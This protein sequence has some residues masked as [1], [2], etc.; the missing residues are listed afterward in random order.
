MRQHQPMKLTRTAGIPKELRSSIQEF[1]LKASR[2]SWR[3]LCHF[4]MNHDPGRALPCGTYIAKIINQ[5]QP[6]VSESYAQMTKYKVIMRCDV[7]GKVEHYL[8][9]RLF[10]VGDE[11]SR[12]LQIEWLDTIQSPVFKRKYI[13]GNPRLIRKF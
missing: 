5:S 3:L 11:V 1:E 6:H 9:P 10:W 4:L 13:R 8:N 2:L 7:N 12:E